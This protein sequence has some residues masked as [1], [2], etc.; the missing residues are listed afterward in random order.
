MQEI[1]C[2]QG[3]VSHFHIQKITILHEDLNTK[4][5][6]LS[7]PALAIMMAGSSRRD[8]PSYPIGLFAL[9]GWTTEAHLDTPQVRPECP[10]QRNFDSIRGQEELRH[11]EEKGHCLY[12]RSKEVVLRPQVARGLLGAGMSTI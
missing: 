4:Q 3:R 6:V 10:Y 1:N 7:S 2:E 5:P 8:L 12:N 9:E 11:A